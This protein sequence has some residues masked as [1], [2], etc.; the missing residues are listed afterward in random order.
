[1][2]RIRT[3]TA[4]CRCGVVE[5]TDGGNSEDSDVL[6]GRVVRWSPV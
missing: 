5:T 3:D 6:F 4:T 1:M 2:Q